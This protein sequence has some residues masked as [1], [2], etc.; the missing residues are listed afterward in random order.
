MTFE[1][2]KEKAD[3]VVDEHG[4]YEIATSKEAEALLEQVKEKHGESYVYTVRGNVHFTVDNGWRISDRVG[5]LVGKNHVDLSR[6]EVM[7]R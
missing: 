3:L 5:F 2:F 4:N 7:Y 1:E 6:I